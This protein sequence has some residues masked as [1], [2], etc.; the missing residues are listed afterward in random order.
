MI[1]NNNNSI[2]EK[3]ILNIKNLK[4]LKLKNK[5]I[6]IKIIKNLHIFYWENEKLYNKRKLFEKKNITYKN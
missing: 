5:K 4:F 3:N 1:I 6:E 2:K